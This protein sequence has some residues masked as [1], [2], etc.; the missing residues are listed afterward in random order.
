MAR[1]FRKRSKKASRKSSGFVDKADV[2]ADRVHVELPV[3]MAV[4]DQKMDQVE[5]PCEAA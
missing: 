1:A 2:P 3:L 5:C 4:L